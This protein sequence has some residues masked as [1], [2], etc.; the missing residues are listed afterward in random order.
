M[1]SQRTELLIGS[2]NL[3]ILKNANVIIFGLGGVGGTAFEALVRAG[4]GNLSIVDFDNVDVTN[5][6]RQIITTLDAIGLPKVEVA[7]NRALS[8]SED[9]NLTVYHE[10]F[11]KDNS[12][13]FF[14]DKKYDYIIDAIDLV[15][16]KLDLIELANNLGIPIISSMGTGNKLNPSSFEVADIKN[17]SV[18]PLAK[19][20][21]KELRAR[22]IKKLKVVYSKELPKKPL[23]TTGS[24]E[25]NKN[26]GSISFVPPVVGYIL[27][28]EVIKDICKL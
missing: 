25:K 26:V 3:E 2:E 8:I 20:V 23:N 1:F 19:I 16:P 24:R 11:L 28:G 10:K 5:L 7:K 17:T 18:C 22:G 12:D 13:L 6:N 27:A 15:T 4:I 14:K 21:R 9:I